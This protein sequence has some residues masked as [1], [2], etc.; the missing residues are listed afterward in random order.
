LISWRSAICADLVADLLEDSAQ[1]VEVRASA[2]RALGYTKSVAVTDSLK[3]VQAKQPEIRIAVLKAI[4]DIRDPAATEVLVA[5]LADS[6]EQV[7]DVAWL[8]LK[9]W[10]LGEVTEQ[11]RGVLKEGDEDARRRAATILAYHL[12]PEANRLLYDVMGGGAEVE[13]AGVVVEV[14]T[15]TIKDENEDLDLRRAAVKTLGA[16][17]TPASVGVLEELL[18]P[19][20]Q[21]VS[22]AAQSLAQIGLR[23]AEVGKRTK[24]GE[25]A[26]QLITVLKQAESDELR[27]EAARALATMKDIPV[28]VLLEGL[29]GYPEEI[30]PWAAGILASIG[31][32]ATDPTLTVRARSKDKQQRLWCVGVLDAIGSKLATRLIKYLPDEEKPDTSLIEQVHEM[33]GRILQRM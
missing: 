29:H 10:Q 2:V 5:G 11:L 14:L 32:P 6:S 22:E 19:G 23:A 16:V 24:M 7:R 27:L 25:A 1:S 12:S 8:A 3:A 26:E 20:S 17:A 4:G 18:A 15:E 31:E 33:K 21:F 13:Q 30:K 28:P 9:R